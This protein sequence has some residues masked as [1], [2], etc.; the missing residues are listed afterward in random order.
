MV[1]ANVKLRALG[2]ISITGVPDSA[3]MTRAAQHLLAVLISAGPNGIERANLADELWV[4]GRPNSWKS[5]LRN[6]LTAVRK[7]VGPDVL[8]PDA[9]RVRFSASASIDSWE[10]IDHNLAA[11]STDKNPLEF[12]EGDPLCDVPASPLVER[13]RQVVADARAALIPR[14]LSTDQPL[15]DLAL[16]T[17]RHYQQAHPLEPTV[18]VGAVRAHLAAGQREYAV[19]L[20]SSAKADLT[21]EQ[22]RDLPWISQ[23]DELLRPD[24]EPSTEDS[25]ATAAEEKARN[26]ARAEIFAKAEANENW[27]MALQIALAGLPEAE[28]SGGDP[29]RLAL[30]ERIPLD[31]LDVGHKFAHC[32]AMAAHLMYSGRDEESRAWARTTSVLAKTPNEKLL[33]FIL[34]A[35][36]GEGDDERTPIPLPPEFDTAPPTSIATQSIQVAV[37]N[38]LERAAFAQTARL[39]RR[40]VSLVE[41]SAEPYRRW[42]MMLLDAMQH[43]VDGE[44]QAAER[45]SHDAYDYASF[46]NIH[47][48]AV[49]LLGQLSN[50]HWIHSG[51]PKGDLAVTSADPL[52]L[53]EALESVFA[54]PS[55]GGES[56]NDFLGD[57]PIESRTYFAFPTIAIVAHAVTDPTLKAR[58]VERLKR[59]TETSAIWGTGVMHLGPVDRILA[60]LADSPADQQMHLASATHVADRQGFRLWRVVCRLDLAAATKNPVHRR[61]AEALASTTELQQ[62]TAQYQSFVDE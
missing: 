56:A 57:F 30:L 44:L 25:E 23:L 35:V 34:Q 9:G 38:H 32:R 14:V 36:T 37:M 40:F 43:F 27:A 16:Q 62:L 31:K 7:V 42:H 18:T 45:A 26:A 2:P 48:A 50:A 20:V 54:A 24:D 51:F 12:L 10:L 15:P 8:D 4:E 33:A 28:K 5:S 41:A 59:R 61:E 46:F 29:E 58:L 39:Q 55:T 13:H 22:C 52:R 6:R 49:P 1:V 17:L 21:D 19:R 11:I 47:D 3:P 53:R 60:R